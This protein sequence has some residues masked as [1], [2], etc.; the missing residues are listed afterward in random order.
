LSNS[1]SRHQLRSLVENLPAAAV[2]REGNTL[3]LNK[4]VE[5][6][7]G[8]LREEIS[9]VDDWFRLVHSGHAENARILYEQAREACFPDRILH[10]YTRKNGEQRAFEVAAYTSEDGEV[11]FLQ[12]IT[13]R[14]EMERELLEGRLR[15]EL[16]VRGSSDGLWDW[17]IARHKV[18]YSP[19][20][21]ELLGFQE[22]DIAHRPRFLVEQV[23]HDDSRTIKL[24]L[25][26]HLQSRVPFDVEFRLRMRSGEYRWFRA[27][28]LAVWND[29][30]KAVRMA[31]SISDITLRKRAEQ[32]LQNLVEQ[33]QDAQRKAETA[34]SAKSEF[35]A[36]MSHEIRT[37]MHGVLGMTGLLLDTDLNAEQR[38]YAETVRHSAESLLTV[39][40]DILDISKLE[41][42]K[43]Q[44][45]RLPCD[46]EGLVAGVVSLL[47]PKAREKNLDLMMQI[48]SDVPQTVIADPA[49]LRQILLNVIG[50]AVKFTESGFVSTQVSVANW[51]DGTTEL[52]ITVRD[53]GI[54]IPRE[55]Q[56][57]LFEQFIQADASTTRR[58]GGTGLGLAICRKLLDV[59]GGSV[60][61][62]SE[63]AKGSTFTFLIPVDVP[64]SSESLKKAFGLECMER[65]RV[66]V[67][68]SLEATRTSIAEMVGG[69]GAFLRTTATVTSIPALLRGAACAGQPFE[70]LIVDHG[71][72]VIPYDLCRSLQASTDIHVRVIVITAM[73]RRSDR[74]MLEAAGAVGILSKPLRAKDLFVCLGTLFG[75]I[76]ESAPAD[77]PSPA[78]AL[79]SRTTRVLV[80]ED[81]VINQRLAMR[82]LE[83]FGC[84]VDLAPNGRD[85]V[86]RWEQGAYDLILMD[87]QMPELD[88]YEATMEIRNRESQRSLRRTP[89]VAMTANAL[90]GDRERCL[91]VGMDDF[92]PKPVQ[93]DQLH[94]MLRHFA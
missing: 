51:R 21:L 20:F 80:A 78:R 6:M 16:A 59:M 12:D 65:R 58:Y 1:G 87:C 7:T 17:D 62:E 68:S 86:T 38:E 9:T 8:Y 75:G 48:A 37:P 43:L 31:G 66:L 26:Q 4:A 82:V 47:T 18:Y 5:Q 36:H 49:R 2:F 90:D 19:R 25:R 22:Q 34:A 72:E 44:L 74:M 50:N 55:K 71:P 73:R 46:V 53:T 41:A 39:L 33:L 35:L 30:G 94:Q 56:G 60:H 13:H 29:Q 52:H 24:A 67:Y 70:V 40:N 84:A 14:H 11:W 45:E 91:R 15:F 10:P 64:P 81:N 28:G 69:A 76:A 63:P 57:T 32:E 23:H 79:P 61:L 77:S 42:G 88:G 83:K 3:I 92:L 89:I 93:I 85:A 54:G 27:R